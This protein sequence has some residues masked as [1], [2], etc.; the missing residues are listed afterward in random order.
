MNLVEWLKGLMV[1]FG[2]AWVMW[3]MVILSVISVAIILERA[4]FF[5]SLR[6]DLAVLARELRAALE[7]SI[8]AA[9]KRMERS[10]S[11]EAAVV[12]AGLAVADKGP[13]AAREAMAGAA[14]LQRMKLERRL[15]YLATLGN[16][17]P[18]IGLFGTVI[19][20]VG[21]FEALG[22]SAKTPVAEVATQAIA[23]QAVMSSIAEALV[24]T[25]I[26]IAIAIPA[27]AANNYFQRSTKSTLANTE[28]LSR[29]LLSHLRADNGNHGDEDDEEEDG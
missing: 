18:F 16:N 11:A 22:E 28:A 10:P 26:G 1:G 20:V 27:V 17:A 21:A 29:V 24:A 3:L 14:A 5:F 15:A 12:L 25:A 2:A 4:W 9:R 23:P 6:D 13:A 19:G 7:K 8:S